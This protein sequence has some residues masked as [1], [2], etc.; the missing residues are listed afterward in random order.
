ML[1]GRKDGIWGV[2]LSVP[3]GSSDE[4]DDEK[5]YLCPRDLSDLVLKKGH[6]GEL[7]S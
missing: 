6:S 7:A 3:M 5:L 1:A 4:N 2:N